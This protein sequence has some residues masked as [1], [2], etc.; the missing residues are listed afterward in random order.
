MAF[1]RQTIEDV[2]GSQDRDF[3]SISV[4]ASIPEAAGLIAKNGIGLLVVGPAC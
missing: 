3:V 2:L 1:S 4:D